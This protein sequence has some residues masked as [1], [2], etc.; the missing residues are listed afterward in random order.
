[1]NELK[2][3]LIISDCSFYGGG[4]SFIA[5]TLSLLKDNFDTYFLVNNDYLYNL[6]P[7]DKRFIFRNKLFLKQLNQAKTLIKELSVS[8]VILNGGNTLFYTPFINKFT[9]K[10]MYRHATYKSISNLFKRIIYIFLI[11][12][13]YLFANKVIHVSNYSNNEQKI[14][15]KNAI[16]V[17]NGV[18]LLKF[19]ERKF[20]NPLKYLF[21]GRTDR[22]KGI[23]TLIDT[24]LQIPEH[25]A[26]LHIVG[27]GEYDEYIKKINKNNI[28][29]YGFNKD[30]SSF[31]NDCDIF[32]LLTKIENC[33]LS[34][35]DALNHSMPVIT[36]N[37]G[38]NPELI[39]EKNGFFINNSVNNFIS[40]IY[41]IY[42][43]SEILSSMGK[44]ANETVKN[45]FNKINTLNKIITIIN[46]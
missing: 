42:E 35:L 6:L 26:V 36:T 9:K 20:T 27:S 15:R 14:K 32:I 21:L 33:S 40:L 5:N 18:D 46:D 7:E 34:I 24:F 10:I 23:K 12:I 1:M 37:V 13:C 31:Y 17:S 38:G 28:V 4:E 30:T 43:N 25:I 39:N 8:V 29:Y 41:S 11:H 44:N 19:K 22:T 3:I 2:K 45:K 16:T